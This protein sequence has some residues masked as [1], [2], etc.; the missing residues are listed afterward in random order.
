MMAAMDRGVIALDILKEN[1]DIAKVLFG[2]NA[3]SNKY[4][5]SVMEGRGI[6]EK[7]PPLWLC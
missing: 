7:K 4:Q 3:I 6:G 2:L 5:N 1:M